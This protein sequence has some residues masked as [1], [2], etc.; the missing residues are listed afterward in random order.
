M[1]RRRGA[2]RKAKTVAYELILRDSILGHSVYGMLDDLVEQHHDELRK[3]R[4][5]LAW[6]RSWKPD[7]DGRWKL[8]MCRRA[9]DLDRELVS[10]DFIILLNQ[11]FWN[12][13]RVTDAQRLA[14]LDHELCHAGLRYDSNGEPVEDE[15]GRLVYRIR[16]HDIEEFTVIVKRHGCYKADLEEFYAALRSAGQQPFAPCDRCKDSPGF[17]AI[18]DDQGVP[19]MARCACWLQWQQQRQEA[20]AS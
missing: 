16:K 7:V 11:T 15:R 18:L 8:G 13:T 1:G 20:I 17:V 4:I 5:A 3:A 2:A 6:S 9:S 10:Y 12:D 14:L 19:R